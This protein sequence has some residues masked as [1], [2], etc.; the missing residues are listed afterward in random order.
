[1]GQPANSK[2]EDLAV[3]CGLPSVALGTLI[4]TT[5]TDA[6]GNT[7]ELAANIEARAPGH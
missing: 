4:S 1:M 3:Y 6:D 7:E 2:F 5:A